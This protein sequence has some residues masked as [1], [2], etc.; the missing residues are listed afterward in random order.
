MSITLYCR[1]PVPGQISIEEQFH[2]IARAYPSGVSV[3]TSVCRFPSRGFFRRLYNMLEAVWRQ[4]EVNHITGD[5]HYLALLLRK[6]KTILTIHDCGILYGRSWPARTLLRWFWFIL[7][8]WRAAI[9]TAIS[10]QTRQDLAAV[11]GID[12]HE[13]RLVPDCVRNDFTWSPAPF[14]SGYPEIL[15][16]GARPNKN[17]ARLAQALHGIPCR[18]RIV[19]RLDPTAEQ[20]L[21]E[22]RIDCINEC[23]L[24]RE[25]IAAR[26]RSCDLVSFVSTFEGFGVPI[27][28]AQATG[29]P[30]VTSDLSPMRDVAGGGACLVDPFDPG[31]IRRGILR[32][33]EQPGY[34][35]SL[36]HQGRANAV[37]YQP[38]DIAAQYAE[39]YRELLSEVRPTLRSGE[40][41]AD[42]FPGRR[43]EFE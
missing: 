41:S 17:V 7:P 13:I 29:R 27:L 23:G 10:E 32:V 39:I 2:Q 6:R 18:L 26:Y 30:V 25:E 19:G 24:T 8:A 34:R 28:E 1:R 36:L 4:G 5:V 33:I 3:T 35:E 43:K 42:I 37:R 40:H 20:A 21:R 14:H 38:H 9:I 22:H 12:P 15:Q 31:S 11:L 16:V